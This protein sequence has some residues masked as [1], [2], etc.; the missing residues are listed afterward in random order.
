M[1]VDG[2]SQLVTKDVFL[3]NTKVVTS[4]I[5]EDKGRKKNEIIHTCKED[6]L[7]K[8]KFFIM[9]SNILKCL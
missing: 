5:N 7:L 6:Q 8:E 9:R 1:N 2:N 3:H 4:K